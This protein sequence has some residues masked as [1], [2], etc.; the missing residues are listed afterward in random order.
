MEFVALG[1]MAALGHCV[2]GPYTQ[3]SA[4]GSALWA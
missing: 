1:V 4:P 2:L 3:T